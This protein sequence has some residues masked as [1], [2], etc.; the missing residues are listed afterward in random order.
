MRTVLTDLAVEVEAAQWLGLRLATAVDAGEDD[1]RRIALPMGKYYVC[2]RARARSSRRWR[3]WAA[4]A[5]SRTPGCRG[6]T[7]R[8]RS[9]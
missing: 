4:P 2:K 5:T 1:F 6:Y 3:R 8:R 7:G 9:T